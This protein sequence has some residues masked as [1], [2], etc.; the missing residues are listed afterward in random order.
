MDFSSM[1]TQQVMGE[2]LVSLLAVAFAAHIIYHA[3]KRYLE[4]RVGGAST[5]HQDTLR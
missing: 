1:F 2:S 5:N 4:H 3:T